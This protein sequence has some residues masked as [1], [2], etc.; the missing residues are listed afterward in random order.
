[1]SYYWEGE[2]I[3]LNEKDF[4]KL[5]KT[6]SSIDLSAELAVMDMVFLDEQPKKWYVAML[7]KLKHQ[8]DKAKSNIATQAKPKT[9]RE[10]T[11]VENLTDR[12]WANG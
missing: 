3:K 8:N 5:E 9:T 10:L 12:S 1:M 4:D 11:L 2:I 7:Y 6:F